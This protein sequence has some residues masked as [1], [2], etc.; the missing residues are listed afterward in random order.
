MTIGTVAILVGVGL[1]FILKLFFEDKEED[2]EDLRSSV[3]ENLN[4]D[5]AADRS[6]SHLPTNIHYKD[7]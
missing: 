4:N 3:D 5:L 6:W 2:Y 1:I 7:S